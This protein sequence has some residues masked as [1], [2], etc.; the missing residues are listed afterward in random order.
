MKQFIILILG[1][2]VLASCS[3][4][5]VHSAKHRNKTPKVYSMSQK[6]KEDVNFEAK[7][8][9]R[10]IEN[11]I[12]HKKANQKQADKKR[13]LDQ[14]NLNQLNAQSK[15]KKPK[16]EATPFSFYNNYKSDE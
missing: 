15:L 14:E 12:K 5:K 4:S 2:S 10:I 1:L 6:E 11:N 8:A 13:Q 9:K 7:Q 3:S 16:K